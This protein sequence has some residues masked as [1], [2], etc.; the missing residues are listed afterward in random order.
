MNYEE[1]YAYYLFK[2]N[3]YDANFLIM[4]RSE[5]PTTGF[6][7]LY[8]ITKE[9]AE[10]L[11]SAS[12]SVN[13]KGSVWSPALAIDIDD[14]EYAKKVESELRLFGLSYRMYNTGNRGAHFYVYRPHAPSHVL[15]QI[16]REWVK[17]NFPQADTSIYSNLHLFRQ[18]GAIH[19]KTGNRKVLV[20][21]SPGPNFLLLPDQVTQTYHTLHK[22]GKDITES[23]FLDR[24][25]MSMTVPCEEGKRHETLLNL[26]VMLRKRGESVE[27]I[28]GWLKN[29]NLL[30]SEPKSEGE[31]ERIMSFVAEV[32]VD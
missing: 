1:T 20:G 2:F 23:I 3:V 26:G 10:A 17:A 15:P 28:E 4:H 7:S 27:F 14:E 9:D 30:F 6:A 21:Q 31:I 13:F 25:I 12:T 32:V 22:S 29:S 16:D 18:I 5:L 24:R 11:V 19:D 8:A